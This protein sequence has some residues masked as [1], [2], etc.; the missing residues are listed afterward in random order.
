MAFDGFLKLEGIPGSDSGAATGSLAGFIVI[1]SIQFSIHRRTSMRI[2]PTDLEGG[3]APDGLAHTSRIVVTKA[4]DLTSTSLIGACNDNK[5]LKSGEIQL[6]RTM[7]AGNRFMY[8]KIIMKKVIIAGVSLP[9]NLEGHEVLELDPSVIEITYF[10]MSRV[11]PNG[12]S[13]IELRAVHN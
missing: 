13:M 12:Q 5:Q 11:G 3:D 10:S 4:Y 9:F 8:S 1:Q 6:F 2:D 7:P